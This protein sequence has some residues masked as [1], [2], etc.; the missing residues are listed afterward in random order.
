MHKSSKREPSLNFCII[1]CGG[2]GSRLAPELR[3]QYPN[4][5]ILFVDGDIFEEKNLDRQVFPA[6]A[7]GHNK[8]EVMARMHNGE[9]I[10]AMLDDTTTLPSY[11]DILFVAV[12][13]HRARRYSLDIADSMNIGCIVCANEEVE[14]Q[15]YW[16]DP[17]MRGTALD[18]RVRF[19]NLSTD[20]RPSGPACVTAVIESDG[21]N[22]TP[23]A[24]MMASAFGLQ[25]L[26]SNTKYRKSLSDD[27]AVHT[28]IELQSN[29]N[30][31][32]C[33]KIIDFAVVN[34]SPT[35]LI[36]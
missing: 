24:N 27:G 5:R 19:D 25:L 11:V 15:S 32:R 22:Q 18:P 8:A 2:V 34:G 31:I 6:E 9:A 28:V 21:N 23:L 35:A 30:T 20:P 12:D 10:G 33:K 17:S 16:Y 36:N 4:A 3:K 13:N 26:Y 1:G 14:A 7:L 29:G